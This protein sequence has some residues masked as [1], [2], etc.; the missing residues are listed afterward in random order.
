M[1]VDDRDK[2]DRLLDQGLQQ[3]GQA[4][5]R[6]G[7]ELRILAAMESETHRRSAW[8]WQWLAM[9]LAAAAVL[10][11]VWLMPHARQPE[12]AHDA[13]KQDQVHH[14]SDFLASKPPQEERVMRATGPVVAKATGTR[15]LAEVAQVP[16]ERSRR[17]RFPTPAPLSPQ[18]QLL[19]RYVT[20]FHN[21]AVLTAQLQTEQRKVDDLA[22]AASRN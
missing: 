2:F 6:P 16:L 4:E 3:F 19:A 13:A 15:R 1:P 21:D 5:P 18:E 22:W 7:L 20:E 10:V 8:G 12:R 9:G 14:T 11:S 17:E